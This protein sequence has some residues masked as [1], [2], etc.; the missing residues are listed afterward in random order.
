MNEASL[1]DAMEMFEKYGKREGYEPLRGGISTITQLSDS[2]PKN[3]TEASV[4]KLIKLYGKH[5]DDFV[6][7]DER[8]GAPNCIVYAKNF[9]Q[10]AKKIKTVEQAKLVLENGRRMFWSDG[11]INQVAN[12]WMVDKNAPFK[13]NEEVKKILDEMFECAKKK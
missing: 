4:T 11:N 5:V 12:A 7:P 6:Y 10:V 13:G 2:L 9:L 1:Y 8:D 3:P